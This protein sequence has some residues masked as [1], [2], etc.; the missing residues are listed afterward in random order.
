MNIKISNLLFGA[1]FVLG[2]LLLLLNRIFFFEFG[3]ISIVSLLLGIG[4]TLTFFKSLAKL[5]F[6]GI[7]FSLAF[8]CIVF[9]RP[10]HLWAIT[11]WPVLWAALF[12]SIGCSMIFKGKKSVVPFYY[13][14]NFKEAQ[15][16]DNEDG[17]QFHFE[18]AFGSAVKYVNS[19]DFHCADLDCSF[20]GMKI[21]F[22]HATV[23]KGG[24]ATINID[25]AFS[26]VDLYIP[27]N[28]KVIVN[29]SPAFG[30]VTEKNSP[31]IVTD[32]TVFINGDVSFSG[33][34]IYYV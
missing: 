26:G 21:Y 30:G 27:R 14:N 22:D 15:I 7:F 4:F 29:A 13:N 5:D 2:G 28:W 17:Q 3:T 34:S 31:D 11:P 6:Y 18:T 25:A 33:V 10:L 9:S 8:L 1:L 32:C 19:D 23:A 20:G 12:F 24:Q 16:F